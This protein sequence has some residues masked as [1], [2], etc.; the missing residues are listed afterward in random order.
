MA[1]EAKQD[2]AII[3]LLESQTIQKAA[4]KVGIS[5][6]TLFNWLQEPEFQAAYR[7]ARSR[8]FESNLSKLQKLS[9]LAMNTL[10]R[11]LKCG[12]PLAEIA[13]ARSIL[14][15]SVK[16]AE[17]FDVMARIDAVEQRLDERERGVR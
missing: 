3:A 2:A 14:S 10:K 17:M 6:R 12:N 1:L 11:N 9:T 13:A 5:E 15:Y 16:A 8:L 4:Q 7:A